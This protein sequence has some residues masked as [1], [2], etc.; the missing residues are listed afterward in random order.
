MTE[1]EILAFG[2]DLEN[3]FTAIPQSDPDANV[4]VGSALFA[5]DGVK[6]AVR[7]LARLKAMHV[8]LAV[9]IGTARAVTTIALARLCQ[10]VVTI[11]IGVYP[12][13][14][15]VLKW[16]G[17]ENACSV[18]VPNDEHKALLLNDLDFDF[19][20]I[21]GDHT[22]AGCR[23]DFEQVKR[24]GCV[25][26]HDYTP[27]YPNG[28]QALVDSMPEENVIKDYPFA[29]WFAD[30]SKAEHYRGIVA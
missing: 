26:F 12:L 10:R 7:Q 17:A 20:F 15:E 27:P 8:T 6:S 11:D 25:L 14:V 3:R 4:T 23:F 13:R 28:P 21:D 1:S 18:V 5:H 29:W 22:E 9:E 16:G 30:A 24:C 2:A 19:A